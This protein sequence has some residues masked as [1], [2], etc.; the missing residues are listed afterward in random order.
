V[1]FDSVHTGFLVWL[2][3]ETALPVS[4]MHVSLACVT[5]NDECLPKRFNI[6][7][8]LFERALH[9]HKAEKVRKQHFATIIKMGLNRDA[10]RA[11]HTS[12]SV[13]MVSKLLG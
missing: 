10:V 11:F 9:C 3:D 1:S 7:V 13:D 5:I 12:A 8:L 6:L 4:D 2:G